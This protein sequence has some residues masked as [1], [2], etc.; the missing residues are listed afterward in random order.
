MVA[1]ERFVDTAT[2]FAVR[3]FRD[4]GHEELCSVFVEDDLLLRIQTRGR[5]RFVV[6]DCLLPVVVRMI[7]VLVGV[8][9]VVFARAGFV[10]GAAVADESQGA[11]GGGGGFAAAVFGVGGF[12][13][14]DGAEGGAVVFGVGGGGREFGFGEEASEAACEARVEDWSGGVGHD[15]VGRF[16][17]GAAGGGQV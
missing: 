11:G 8:G 17:G 15:G 4:E 5:G 3:A 13:A 12:G 14:F 7:S 10:R 16:L 2:L 1:F 9:A 6:L